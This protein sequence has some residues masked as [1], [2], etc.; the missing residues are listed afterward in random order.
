MTDWTDGIED[1]EGQTANQF[2]AGMF[3]WIARS[4]DTPDLPKDTYDFVASSG[5][6]DRMNDSID[7]GTWKLGNFRKNP[8]I[9]YEHTTPMIGKGLVKVHT[10]EDGKTKELRA[11]ITFHNSPTN[12]IG[13]MV[14]EQHANGFRKAVSVGF[15]PGERKNRTEIDPNDPNFGNLYVDPKTIP[16]KWLAGNLFRHNQLLEISSVSIPAHPDALQMGTDGSAGI[17]KDFVNGEN[18]DEALR[19]FL[20]ET[21]PAAVR[22]LVLTSLRSDERVRRAIEAMTLGSTPS[23]PTAPRWY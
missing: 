3:S 18:R 23:T 15:L 5:T 4:L 12:P 9:L 2:R 22:D 20:D 14:A 19:K 10:L 8:A 6:V 17:M 7:Q 13:A 11:R 21:L 1:E 16:Y